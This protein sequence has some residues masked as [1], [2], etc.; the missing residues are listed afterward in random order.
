MKERGISVTPGTFGCWLFG[1]KTIQHLQA[2]ETLPRQISKMGLK[3]AAKDVFLMLEV[4]GY[5]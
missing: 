4:V 3:R 2:E 1:S 5:N